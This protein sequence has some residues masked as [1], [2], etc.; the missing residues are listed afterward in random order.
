MDNDLTLS[1]CRDRISNASFSQRAKMK[2]GDLWQGR[3]S[4][5]SVGAFSSRPDNTWLV[6][7]VAR[8]IMSRST[9]ILQIFLLS[10]SPLFTELHVSTFHSDPSL[11]D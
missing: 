8:D 2:G 7:D 10:V 4:D 6:F 1:P 5:K 11:I 3:G 9:L